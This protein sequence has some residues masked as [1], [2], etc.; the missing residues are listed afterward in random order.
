MFNTLRHRCHIE[1]YLNHLFQH[2]HCANQTT[3]INCIIKENTHTSSIGYLDL[4][5]DLHL[6]LARVV[7]QVP[8]NWFMEVKP[9]EV[10]LFFLDT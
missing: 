3:S 2:A 1:N 8:Q 5:L 10:P 9:M 7:N 4:C 6:W